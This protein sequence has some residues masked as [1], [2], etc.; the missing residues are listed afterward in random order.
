LSLV[1]ENYVV[2]L[3]D[4]PCCEQ[5]QQRGPFT[6]HARGETYGLHPLVREVVF[7][8]VIVRS[9][10]ACMGADVAVYLVKKTMS[11]TPLLA[12]PVFSHNRN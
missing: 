6:K 7:N 1:E 10:I 11:T 5:D 3:L 8:S 12:N 9:R 2:M 4:P